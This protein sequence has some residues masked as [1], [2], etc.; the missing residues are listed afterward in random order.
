MYVCVCVCA[1][2][3]SSSPT[4]FGE[5]CFTTGLTEKLALHA[6]C[7]CH[8]SIAVPSAV[9]L[10]VSFKQVTVPKPVAGPW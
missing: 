1:V 2:S 10:R 8:I 3:K 5:R 9:P 4:S 6:K 7:N